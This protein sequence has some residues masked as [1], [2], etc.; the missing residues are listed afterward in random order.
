MVVWA[1]TGLWHGA[2]WCYVI[3][4]LYYGVLLLLEKYVWGRLLDR[5]PGAVRHIYT[6]IL[7][8]FGWLIFTAP[9]LS[10]LGANFGAMFGAYG[11]AFADG[12]AWY[13]LTSNLILLIICTLCS[14]PLI[15]MIF[16]RIS[17]A[18]HKAGQIAAIVIYGGLFIT[19]LAYLVNATYNPFL[20]FK[21]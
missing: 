4:G 6:I 7:F 9:S 19:S 13:Y 1:L 11:N 18:S 5:L 20:Y 12:A 3:W 8:V 17:L 10:G 21:F 2:A 14:T 16:G 15:K